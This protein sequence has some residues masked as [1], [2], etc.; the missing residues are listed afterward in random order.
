MISHDKCDITWHPS[1][2]NYTWSTSGVPFS[3]RPRWKNGNMCS[4]L[5]YMGNAKLGKISTEYIGKSATISRDI[6]DTTWHPSVTNYTWSTSGVP[7]SIR[8]RWN[9]GNICSIFVYVANAKLGKIRIEYIGFSV[10]T[11]RDKC[12]ITNHPSATDYARSTSGVQF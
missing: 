8:L 4:L 3:I 2:T 11:S 5:V 10:T 12:D 9:N 7:F 1:V 6:C